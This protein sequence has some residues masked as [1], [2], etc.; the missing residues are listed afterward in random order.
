VERSG[1]SD[2]AT[3]LAIAVGVVGFLMLGVVAWLLADSQADQR[4]QVRQ[5]YGQR[6]EIATGTVD[7]IFGVAFAGEARDAARDYAAARPSTEQLDDALRRTNSLYIAIL[8]P[9]GE[10]LGA[11]SNVPQDLRERLAAVPPHLR[12]ALDSGYGLSNVRVVDGIAVIETAVAFESPFGRRVR[13]SGT[14][15]ETYREFLGAALARLPRVARGEAWVIDAN[16]RDLARASVPREQRTPPQAFLSGERS[17][18]FQGVRGPTYFQAEPLPN[19]GWRIIIAASERALFSTLGGPSRWLPWAL[20]GLGVAALVVIALL[21]RRLLRTARALRT[22][23]AEL[24]RSNADLEQFAYAAS[25]DLSEPLRTV[26]GFSQLL[27]KRYEGRLDAEADLYI[28]HMG[29]GVERM[30]QLIDDLLL[31]S[32]VG[33]A[34]VA[35]DRVDLGAL[36]D[37]VL[38]SIEPT[39]RERGA[40]ITR[41]DLP[42][43]AGERGQLGQVLQNLLVNAM[44]FTAADVTPRVHVSAARRDGSWEISVRDNGIGVGDDDQVIFKMFGRLHPADEYAGTGIGLALV[45]R[46]LERHG[47][48]IWVRPAPGGGSIFTFSVPDRT[49]VRPPEPVE[50]L[51]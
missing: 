45:K 24:E 19:T 18:T 25:H 9:S 38:A 20:L 43:V 50:A 3:R 49:P 15:L 32:R 29:S 40:E 31:Y 28:E 47:G 37:E 6:A 4:Q 13:L 41:G 51:A 48:D 39:V 21:L 36:L 16:G 22:S 5:A 8:D 26:A 23:N 46:I 34:P 10:V 42:T 12:R 44:K 30:Q 33:R 2:G 11:S 27:G 17:G 35:R 1:P 14:P 7:A